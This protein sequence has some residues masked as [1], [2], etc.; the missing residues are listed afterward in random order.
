[1]LF[2]SNI[3][4]E[5]YYL[6]IRAEDDFDFENKNYQDYAAFLVSD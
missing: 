4:I 3:R 6:R 5:Y 1:V 2:R